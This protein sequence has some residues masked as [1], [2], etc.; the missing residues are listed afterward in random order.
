MDADAVHARGIRATG[1]WPQP[2]LKY[3]CFLLSEFLLCP[4]SGLGAARMVDGTDRTEKLF[5]N[6]L[7]KRLAVVY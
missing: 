1:A 5:V 3:F 7:N 2:R 4:A 6:E